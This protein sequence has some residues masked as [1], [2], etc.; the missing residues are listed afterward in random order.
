M[1]LQ[2]VTQ[3]SP[4]I[5]NANTNLVEYKWNTSYSLQTGTD[6]VTGLYL[7]KLTDSRTGKQ[8]YIQFVLRDDN[9]PTDWVSK[10]PLLRL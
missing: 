2:G 6:W 5:T 4:T 1:D 7:V 8:N 10:M 3:A 9:R